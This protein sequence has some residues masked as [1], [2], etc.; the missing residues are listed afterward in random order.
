MLAAL[1]AGVMALSILAVGLFV[2]AG[3]AVLLFVGAQRLL[4]D[5]D[6]RYRVGYS[7]GYA[8]GYNTTCKIR[9]TLI[10][11]DWGSN[12]YTRGYNIGY[13]DGSAVCLAKR[14]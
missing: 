12:A 1:L 11:G 7:D 3:L 9:T 4:E 6:E 2:I 10:E 13:T 8:V 5:S 14:R